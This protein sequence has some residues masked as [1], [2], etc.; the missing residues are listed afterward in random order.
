MIVHLDLNGTPGYLLTADDE[1][2]RQ[3]QK[4]LENLAKL[5]IGEAD[6]AKLRAELTR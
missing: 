5:A 1:T 4:R 6:A 2:V 3:Y